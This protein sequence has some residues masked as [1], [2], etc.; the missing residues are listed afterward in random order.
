MGSDTPPGRKPIEGIRSFLTLAGFRYWTV[1][2]LPALVGTT[3]P[4]WLRPPEFLFRLLSAV[5]FLLA[6]LFLYVGF[7][8]LLALSEGKAASI[9]KKPRLL[10]Y[11]GACMIVACL[12]GLHLNSGLTF[13]YG[14]PRSIFIIYGIVT[15]FVGALYV[16]PPLSFYRRTGGE[17]VVAEGLGMIPVL[18]AYLVQVGDLTRTV[19]LTSLPLVVATGL[20]V[21]VEELASSPDDEKTGRRTLV[22]DFGLKFSARFGVL[23]LVAAFFGTLVVAVISVSTSPLTLI[24]LVSIVPAWKIVTIAW[25]EY[26]RPEQMITLGKYAFVLHLITGLIFAASPIVI[27][28]GKAG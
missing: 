23:T 11:T 2:L 21:W 4:F 17:I 16:M 7:S 13:H 18:G 5:E 28:F 14:V 6:T 1:S 15:L 10:K 8:F 24:T 20:W 26:T 22:I 12:L 3:L 9:W 25:S 27:L 19:Y